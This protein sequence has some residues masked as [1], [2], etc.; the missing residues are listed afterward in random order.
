MASNPTDLELY[1]AASVWNLDD[2][3]VQEKKP[4]FISRH[5]TLSV[6]AGIGAIYLAFWMA[7]KDRLPG[8]E[9]AHD[10]VES[11]AKV[12]GVY[13]GEL[14]ANPF[15][16]ETGEALLCIPNDKRYSGWDQQV[17]GDDLR[18]DAS[19]VTFCPRPNRALVDRS[20]SE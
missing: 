8:L 4:S 10:C 19:R 6:A 16:D 15:L 3:G 11:R 14:L 17:I 5:P 2:D 13:S 20:I 18:R 12:M 9:I 1:G 7:F